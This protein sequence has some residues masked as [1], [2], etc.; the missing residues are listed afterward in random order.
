MRTFSKLALFGLAAA[1][2]AWWLDARS[3]RK[4]ASLDL[5]T[6]GR[7]RTPS[8]GATGGFAEDAY[9]ALADAVATDD[10]DMAGDLEAL[11]LDVDAAAQ[12]D[13][14]T[15]MD[16]DV[17]ITSRAYVDI[18][19]IYAS[20][21]E[22]GASLEEGNLYGIHT[23]VASDTDLSA[24]EDEDGYRGAMDGESWLEALEVAS[25]EGGPLPEAEIEIEITDD[26]D[27]SVRARTDRR[28]TPIADKGAAGPAGL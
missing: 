15:L 9:D 18:D 4:T 8:V 24:G 14:R 20:E 7:F 17:G 23:S 5:R 3:K 27:H 1:G 11:G 2:L 13:L 12:D 6:T 22:R 16:E 26:G 28:D 21:N 10:L 19:R 25:A